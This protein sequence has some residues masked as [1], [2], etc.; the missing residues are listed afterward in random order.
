MTD[1]GKD[2]ILERMHSKFLARQLLE[3]LTDSACQAIEQQSALYTWTSGREEEFDGLTILALVIARICPNF[4][5]DMFTEITKAKK[6][7]ISQYDND[8]QLYFDAITFLKLQIDQKDSTAYTEDAFIRDLFLQLKN[9]SLPAE[10]RLKFACQVTLWLMNKS[11]VTSQ[12]LMNDAAAY[13]VNLKNTGAWKIEISRNSQIIALT[14]QLTELKME[15]GKLSASKG[16]PKLDDG[17][18]AGGPAKYIFDLWRLEKVDNKVEHNM[19][20]RDGK[21]WYLCD[22]HKYNNKGVITNGMYITHK[23]DG[24]DAWMERRNKGRKGGAAASTGNNSAGKPTT[25]PSVSNDSSASKLS[26]SKSL[27]AALV[28]T[29][30]ITE[31]QFKKIWADACSASG[32]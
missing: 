28:T 22:K 18:P 16:I 29:A 5:V 10:F 14:T 13:F 15:I 12:E 27:Q 24:H 23:P 25:T 31:D 6:L 19:I 9:E 8:V 4:K 17:K 7:S 21:T 3:L 1:K 2:L 32:N 26:L 11:I 20:E 30:G